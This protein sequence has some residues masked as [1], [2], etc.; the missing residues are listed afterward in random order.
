MLLEELGE[1]NA[2]LAGSQPIALSPDLWNNSA[3]QPEDW[4][5]RK[6][7]RE[8]TSLHHCR[9]LLEYHRKIKLDPSKWETEPHVMILIWIWDKFEKGSLNKRI[10]LG[11][12]ISGRRVDSLHESGRGGQF[13]S[14]DSGFPPQLEL[15]FA[16]ILVCC[17]PTSGEIYQNAGTKGALRQQIDQ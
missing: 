17:S 11:W 13:S 2:S 1:L 14:G 3:T 12:N 15:K 6:M 8:G 4:G 5:R 10:N 7:S 9:I 16:P